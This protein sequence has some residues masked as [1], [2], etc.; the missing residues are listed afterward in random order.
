METRLC[1]LLKRL[2]MHVVAVWETVAIVAVG[3]TLAVVDVGETVA[4][5]VV[6]ETGTKE[7]VGET[8]NL[9]SC[10]QYSLKLYNEAH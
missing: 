7:G 9:G 8:N 10:R 4:M 3:K 1:W 5:A 2:L 6:L